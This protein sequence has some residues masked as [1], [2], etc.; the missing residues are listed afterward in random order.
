MSSRFDPRA[1]VTVTG[2]QT[3]T[4]RLFDPVQALN[5][6]SK[7]S[8][9]HETDAKNDGS[10]EQNAREIAINFGRVIGN[11]AKE[12]RSDDRAARGANAADD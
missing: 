3:R 8:L 1:S 4:G 2:A 12:Q 9:R 10:T 11:E 5:Q 7:G 6:C